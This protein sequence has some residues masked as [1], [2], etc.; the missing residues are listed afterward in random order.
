MLEHWSVKGYWMGGGRSECFTG[1]CEMVSGLKS[2]GNCNDLNNH[3][4][5]DV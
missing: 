5:N 3:E 1:A 4:C 2:D